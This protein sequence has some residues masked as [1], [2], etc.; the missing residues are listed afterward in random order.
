M[1]ILFTVRVFATGTRRWVRKVVDC[2]CDSVA[3]HANGKQDNY[4]DKPA[5]Q[6]DY[7]CY[8]VDK[9]CTDVGNN[10]LHCD[11][12]YCPFRPDFCAHNTNCRDAGRIQEAKC[13][14]RKRTCG[15]KTYCACWEQEACADKFVCCGNIVDDADTADD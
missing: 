9:K 5:I 15:R 13:E 10:K 1:G 12:N 14:E 6:Q 4:A 8:F 3:Y 7:A 11:G 2:F